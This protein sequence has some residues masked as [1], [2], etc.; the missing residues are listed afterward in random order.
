MDVFDSPQPAASDFQTAA[1]EANDLL[2]GV[3][4]LT[5]QPC[6]HGKQGP[7][8]S[9]AIGRRSKTVEVHQVAFQRFETLSVAFIVFE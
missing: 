2:N 3:G 4:I 8:N 7:A 9:K 1:S 5:L 6:G